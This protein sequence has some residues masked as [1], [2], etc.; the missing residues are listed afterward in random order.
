MKERIDI[1][2][3]LHATLWT[4]WTFEWMPMHAFSCPNGLHLHP[5]SA[6]TAIIWCVKAKALQIAHWE[7][8][9]TQKQLYSDWHLGP[10]V[11]H[12]LSVSVNKAVC[13][14]FNA[15]DDVG[16]CAWCLQG[17]PCKG[18]KQLCWYS[19][20]GKNMSISVAVVSPK[21]GNSR[22][23]WNVIAIGASSFY[24]KPD[25]IKAVFAR[26][27][28]TLKPTAP[29]GYCGEWELSFNVHRISSSASFSVNTAGGL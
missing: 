9:H 22:K 19:H 24:K 8:G 13:T 1:F 26:E 5:S 20:R 15:A 27:L 29:Q 28:K 17:C 25:G 3:N 14:T 12:G 7:N 6:Y 18:E 4:W 10:V 2:I 21:L 11:S 23:N 16:T